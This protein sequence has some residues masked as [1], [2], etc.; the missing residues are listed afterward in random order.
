M[1]TA[2]PASAAKR[3]VDAEEKTRPLASPKGR[4]SFDGLST[5][6]AGRR[7][8]VEVWRI[9]LSLTPRPSRQWA[10]RTQAPDL[11]AV[12]VQEPRRDER[13]KAR[14]RFVV[15]AAEAADEL[16]HHN[17][18][19]PSGAIVGLDRK[20]EP[21]PG[22]RGADHAFG[23]ALGEHACSEQANDLGIET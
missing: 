5:A 19:R 9:G 16:R 10:S 3:R 12:P 1:M 17:L 23:A 13:L 21:G 11:S 14:G 6:S 15:E 7:A 20:A 18:R 4:S 8:R 22:Q 2:K